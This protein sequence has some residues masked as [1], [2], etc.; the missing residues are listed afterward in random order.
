MYMCMD[1]LGLSLWS[2][3]IH[4]LFHTTEMEYILYFII[5]AVLVLSLKIVIMH[6]Q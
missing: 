4:P 2:A 1:F 3:L 6:R 5:I